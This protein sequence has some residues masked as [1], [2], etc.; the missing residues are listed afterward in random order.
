[1]RED[2]T[3]VLDVE[4]EKRIEGLLDTLTYLRYLTLIETRNRACLRYIL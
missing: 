2:F 3:G 4:A 1:M